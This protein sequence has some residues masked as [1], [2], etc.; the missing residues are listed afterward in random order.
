MDERQKKYRL[1]TII[2]ILIGIIIYLCLL[3]GQGGV[4]SL[5]TYYGKV[6]ATDGRYNGLLVLKSEFSEKDENHESQHTENLPHAIYLPLIFTSVLGDKSPY[7]PV[8]T[9]VFKEIKQISIIKSETPGFAQDAI[10]YEKEDEVILFLADGK[11]GLRVYTLKEANQPQFHTVLNLPDAKSMVIHENTM[12]VAAGKH[13]VIVVDISNP[14]IPFIKYSYPLQGF[15]SDIDIYFK[16]T[17]NTRII[18]TQSRAEQAQPEQRTE[19]VEIIYL[20][21]TAGDEGLVL[22]NAKK[23]YLPED[24]LKQEFSDSVSNVRVD[25]SARAFVG[26]DEGFYIVDFM[27]AP[28][29]ELA[30]FYETKE[31][32]QDISVRNNLAYLAVG[33][34]GLIIVDISNES[35]PK[36]M[37][38]IDTPGFAHAV[39]LKH[40]FALVAD[41]EA[42]IR[43]ID[44]SNPKEPLE[45]GNYEPELGE[46]SLGRTLAD[47][48][49]VPPIENTL[50]RVAIDLGLGIIF[51][52]LGL[53]FIA[54]FVLPIKSISER[55]RTVSRILAYWFGKHGPIFRVDS[56]NIQPKVAKD[57]P[58]GPGVTVLDSDSAVVFHDKNGEPVTH[59]TGVDFYKKK[60][61]LVGT[62][63]LHKQTIPI[64]PQ[65]DEDP[66]AFRLDGETIRAYNERYHRRMETSGQTRDDREVVPTIKLIYAIDTSPPAGGI[67]KGIETAVVEP[68]HRPVAGHRRTPIM[69]HRVDRPSAPYKVDSLLTEMSTKLWR[70]YLRK[71]AFDELFSTAGGGT[72]TT[73]LEKILEMMRMHLM[74]PEV[75]E[76]D[77]HG[78]VTGSVNSPQFSSL[79]EKGLRV[80]AI[81]IE[82]VNIPDF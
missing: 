23:P 11:R 25:S 41:G 12:Y 27:H 22:I 52:F 9:H 60:E 10:V 15:I 72:G 76:L 48:R 43:V 53:L 56:G 19:T 32:V 16:R 46:A 26:G 45:A 1:H 78:K 47:L 42:G 66:F 82:K 33:K 62:A 24:Y 28:D 80:L 54:N 3:R 50:R 31:P 8:I 20:L 79:S 63:D 70:D 36:Y 40:N 2:I 6:Y 7:E 55:C 75:D 69:F 39:E 29:I 59:R 30:G 65:L 64:G 17:T 5:F 51:L 37:G 77:A 74:R 81:T 44:V 38:N 58:S 14:K 18:P 68:H 4:N 34:Q 49:R 35:D 13:G 21:V 71:F 57:P 67:N 61:Y 73:A